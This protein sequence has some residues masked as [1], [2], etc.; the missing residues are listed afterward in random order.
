MYKIL[1]V[2]DNKAS[3]AILKNCLQDEHL[4]VP[5][6]TGLKALVMVE[7][8]MPDLILLDINLPDINGFEVISRL[9]TTE[10]FR[11]IPVIFLTGREEAEVELEGMNLGAADYIRKPFNIALLKKRVSVQ[12]KIVEQ[13][14]QLTAYAAQLREYNHNLE[15][16]VKEKTAAIVD[17][18]RSIISIVTDL[19]EGKDGFTGGHVLRT[20]GYMR[21]FM[22][23]LYTRDML[24]DIKCEDIDMIALFSQLHDV[25]KIR[26]A[27]QVLL[28]VTPLN[29][30]EAMQMRLHTVYGA[31]SIKKSMEFSKRNLYLFYA[32]QM[33][34]SHHEWWDGSGYP[35][36][37]KGGQIPLIARIAAVCDAYDE[38]LSSR[39]FEEERTHADAIRII[40]GSAGTQFDPALTA[41]FADTFREDIPEAR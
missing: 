1:A 11:D 30:V 32:Q 36:A 38:I 6:I 37:L 17:L 24:G 15:Q 18:E 20:S 31:E 35:D 22:R 7:R 10:R 34:R 12:L 26:I 16:M 41:V 33:A 27:D 28:K 13:K 21:A 19:I 40:S 14:R 29:V 8:I 25:G 23:E 9:K 3:L 39:S 4:V 5:V 2:D